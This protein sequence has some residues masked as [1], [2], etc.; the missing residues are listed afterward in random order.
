MAFALGQLFG[1]AI[2]IAVIV[3]VIRTISRRDLTLREKV[4]GKSK[5]PAASATM[6]GMP[7]S[8]PGWYADPSGR[9]EFRWFDGSRW[10]DQV[11]VGGQQRREGTQ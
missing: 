8:Q 10:T 6:S 3:G 11:V 7:S 1:F 4:L 9:S 2:L 5:Q